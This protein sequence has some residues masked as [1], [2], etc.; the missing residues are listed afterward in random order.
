MCYWCIDH[1][2][3]MWLPQF[4]RKMPPPVRHWCDQADEIGKYGWLAHDGV[5]FGV[6]EIEESGFVLKTEFVKRPGGDHGGDWTA[7]FTV[8]PKLP[9]RPVVLS[10]MFYIA[11]DGDGHLE[12]SSTKK[13]LTGIRGIT[14][15]LGQFELKF[16]KSVSSVQK[17]HHLITHADR[18]DELKDVLVKSMSLDN[19]EKSSKLPYFIFHGR[20]VPRDRKANY[21]VHQVT[22]VLPLQ[23]EVIF[24]SGSYHNR[25]SI[26]SGDVFTTE[27]HK[28]QTEFDAKFERLFPLHVKGYGEEDISFAKAALSNLIGSIGYFYGS[29]LVQSVYNEEPVNYWEAP[30]YTGVPSRP[31]FPRGFL[32]DEGFHNLLISQWD[33]S[34]SV[35]IIGHW[36]DLMNTEGWI[37]REQI[38]GVEARAKVPTQFIVQRNKNANPPTFFLPLKSIIKH[39]IE[40]NTVED[41]AFLSA[42]YPRLKAWFTWYNV[43]QVGK[44]STSYRWRGRDEK[45]VKQLNP[46]TLTSG[47]DDFPR[48]SHPSDEEY[49]IDLRCWLALAS[50]V[51]ADIARSLDKNWQVYDATHRRL[52]D[53]TA[54]DELH[55]SEKG[56][57]YSDFGLHTERVRLERPKRPENL[58]PGQR[59][60]PQDKVRTVQEEPHLQFVNSLGYVSLFPFLLKIIDPKSPK[61][62]TVLRD[63]KD[64]ALLWSDYGLRSLSKSAKLYNRYNT[65]HDPPY[66]RGAIWINM[67]YLAL[68]ALDFY[69][70]E[71]GPHQDTARA[72][73]KELRTNIVNNMIKQYRR[74]G[75]IWENYSDK[76][77][78]GKGSHPFTGWSALVV[79]IMGEK[80]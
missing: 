10:L 44:T 8:K 52:M 48:A 63:L 80:Y 53:N 64:P 13:R 37:P 54:L 71:S 34:I 45:A 16:P 43:S 49:H 59:P 3:L 12:E 65:E 46:L 69:S 55:W 11:L 50:G 33:E 4:T 75:Y 2:R 77:G 73:Y 25:P 21:I 1:S 41:K 67:N 78:E 5:H 26:L 56:Q 23:M 29:S 61:L 39:K 42:L 66:W 76:T 27:L 47:L 17:F 24:E 9:D 14:P 15:E 51:M 40:S 57:Q 60:P 72:I 31:F 74:T 30:L 35:D 20:Y 70:R 32:W 36:F 58:Q 79:L 68:D 18:L 7:R 22:A 19:W 6:Q 62:Y 38:L 28:Y